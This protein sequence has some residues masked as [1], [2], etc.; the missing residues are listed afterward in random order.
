MR[1]ATL[2]TASQGWSGWLTRNLKMEN[3][4][5]RAKQCLNAVPN[6][7]GR[8]QQR[9][10]QQTSRCRE[11]PSRHMAACL[12]GINNHRGEM[13]SANLGSAHGCEP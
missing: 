7:K 4:R 11:F 3:V 12:H 2:L 6:P 8:K 9:T 5:E 1:A 13:T 10:A